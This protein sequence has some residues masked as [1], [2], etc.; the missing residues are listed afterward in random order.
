MNLEHEKNLRDPT[1]DALDKTMKEAMK[2]KV[3][4]AHQGLGKEEASRRFPEK[5]VGAS[6]STPDSVAKAKDGAKEEKADEKAPPAADKKS[7]KK[8]APP[9]EEKVAVNQAI[10]LGAFQK[11]PINELDAVTLQ[12]DQLAQIKVVAEKLKQLRE[13]RDQE[14]KLF[15]QEAQ[16]LGD[17]RKQINDQKDEL[18]MMYKQAGI[19]IPQM[20]NLATIGSKTLAH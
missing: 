7:E 19:A 17:T 12:I 5:T 18:K 11:T 2:N 9:A 14:K 10:N 15:D 6:P 8:G 16:K 4:G 13:Q 1:I 20:V 3:D